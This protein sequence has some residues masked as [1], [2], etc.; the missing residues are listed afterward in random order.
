MKQLNEIFLARELI[1]FGDG[2]MQNKIKIFLN[3]KNGCILFLS[4][5]IDLKVSMNWKNLNFISGT[6][7]L[8]MLN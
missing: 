2:R 3:V 4:D 8:S 6:M 1:P 7:P 5:S